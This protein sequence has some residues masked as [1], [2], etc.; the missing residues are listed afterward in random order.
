VGKI[1]CTVGNKMFP[2]G[3]PI[4]VSLL[5]VENEVCPSEQK[6]EIFVQFS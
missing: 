1:V 4:Q 3:I 2:A 6:M 5:E